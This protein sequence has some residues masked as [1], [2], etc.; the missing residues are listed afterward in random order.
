MQTVNEP[1]S[2]SEHKTQP[3]RE[4]TSQKHEISKKKAGK[5]FFRIYLKLFFDQ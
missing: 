5:V 1:I 3:K 4:K 2:W